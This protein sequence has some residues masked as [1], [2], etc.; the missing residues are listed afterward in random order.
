MPAQVPDLKPRA[1]PKEKIRLREEEAKREKERRAREEA[2]M[3]K[4]RQGPCLVNK[5]IFTGPNDFSSVATCQ[6]TDDT[7]M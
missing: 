5:R 6:H 4:S 7:H 3:G 1:D 2:L